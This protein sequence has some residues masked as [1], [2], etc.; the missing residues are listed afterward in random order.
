[1]A[2]GRRRMMRTWSKSC[3]KCLGD[4]KEEVSIYD[5]YVFCSSCRYTLTH[6]EKA[7]LI[8]Q[9]VGVYSDGTHPE[10]PKV[11]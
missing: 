9:P 8:A 3:P 7:T 2:A 11:S 5:S 1:M 6:R 4:L 10:Q